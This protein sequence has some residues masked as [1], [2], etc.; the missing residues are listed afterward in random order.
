MKAIP[1]NVIVALLLWANPAAADVPP[2][3]APDSPAG[4]APPNIFSV[5]KSTD[6][7]LYEYTVLI[8]RKFNDFVLDAVVLAY[9]S[10]DEI[11]LLSSVDPV[12]LESQAAVNFTVAPSIAEDVQLLWTYRE[13]DA[14]CPKLVSFE[15]QI[16][17]D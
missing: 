9:I 3:P 17:R 13:P 5:S 6:D 16:E 14:L 15:Y 8:D 1:R 10:D 12:H 4:N 2:C 7:G 11:L